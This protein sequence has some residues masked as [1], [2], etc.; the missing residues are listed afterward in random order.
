MAYSTVP[1]A[2]E[3]TPLSSATA[4][5]AQHP[6]FRVFLAGIGFFTDAYDLFVVNVVLVFM[7]FL[8]PDEF[9]RDAA[10]VAT[11]MRAHASMRAAARPGASMAASYP[12]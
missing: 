11:G 12:R 7:R 10:G 2:T 8:Y 5:W 3:Q 6:K 4:G 9:A 1:A